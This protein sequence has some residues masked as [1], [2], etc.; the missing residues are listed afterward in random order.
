AGWTRILRRLATMSRRMEGAGTCE[1]RPG[2]GWAGRF[3]QRAVVWRRKTTAAGDGRVTRA[4]DRF[5]LGLLPLG[6]DPVHSRPLLRPG[7]LP[8]RV[9][10]NGCVFLARRQ[11]WQEGHPSRPGIFR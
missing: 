3:A 1:R 6:P 10:L 2:G 11:G 7:R 8:R 4:Q 5:C 9:A